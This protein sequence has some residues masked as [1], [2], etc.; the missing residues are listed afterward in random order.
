MS[1]CLSLCTHTHTPSRAGAQY[2]LYCGHHS[3]AQ[4]AKDKEAEQRAAAAA[5]GVSSDSSDTVLLACCCELLSAGVEMEE[6]Y[7]CGGGADQATN[8]LASLGS[9]AACCAAHTAAWAAGCSVEVAR[10]AYLAGLQWQDL[11][12]GPQRHA[13]PCV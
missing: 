8:G 5:A 9:R 11:S 10:L 4:R 12:V 1:R 6:S 13:Q 3:A 2:R 7:S